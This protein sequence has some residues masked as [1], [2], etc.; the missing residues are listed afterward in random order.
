MEAV[1]RFID[2]PGDRDVKVKEVFTPTMWAELKQLMV[3]H[4]WSGIDETE[5]KWLSD[6][7]SRTIIN[8]F[9][10]DKSI[11]E[12]RLVSMPDRYTN[13]IDTVLQSRLDLHELK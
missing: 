3:E 11:G 7:S 2:S 4:N 5:A 13:S 12:K 8:G 10:K 6:F 1:Q 9:I